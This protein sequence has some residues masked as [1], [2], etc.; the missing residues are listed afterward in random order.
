[1]RRAARGIVCG[2]AIAALGGCGA[3]ASRPAARRAVVVRELHEDE[4]ATAGRRPALER[5]AGHVEGVLDL[6]LDATLAGDVG[7]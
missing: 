7:A 5:A 4:H 1:M 2:V 3:T 6:D